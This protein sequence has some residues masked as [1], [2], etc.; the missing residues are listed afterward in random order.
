[1]TY[2]QLQTN[3]IN[4]W[5]FDSVEATES[6]QTRIFST[7]NP[8][9]FFTT[10]D[11][12]YFNL[13]FPTPT[14][15]NLFDQVVLEVSSPLTGLFS[16]VIDLDFNLLDDYIDTHSSF[17][18]TAFSYSTTKRLE[19]RDSVN[20]PINFALSD[21]TDIDKRKGGFSK[22][23]LIDGTKENS[24]TLNFYFDVNLS[25]GQFDRKKRVPCEIIQDGLSIFQGFLRLLKINRESQINTLDQ[26]IIYEVIVADDTA[27]FFQLLEGNIRDGYTKS[28]TTYDG[29]SDL[30]SG[31]DL[32]FM[33][34][35]WDY[36][37]VLISQSN[38]VEE[39]YKYIFPRA[40]FDGNDPTQLF[41]D[42]G[43][44]LTLT[45]RLAWSMQQMLPAIYAKIYWDAIFNS[46]GFTYEWESMNS[47][48]IMFD[49]LLIPHNIEDYPVD[50]ESSV[51]NIGQYW[52]KPDGGWLNTNTSNGSYADISPTL[53][54]GSVINLNSFKIDMLKRDFIKSILTMFNLYVELDREKPNN[55]IVKTRDEFYDS[56]VKKDWTTKTDF[57]KPNTIVFTPE[58][59]Q[60]R[61]IF[62]YSDG[63]RFQVKQYKENTGETSGTGIV[64]FDDEFIKGEKV[65][66]IKFQPFRNQ[67]FL[68][69]ND[70]GSEYFPYMSSR[71]VLNSRDINIVYDVGFTLF[72]PSPSNDIYLFGFNYLGKTNDNEYDITILNTNGQVR[73]SL[74]LN[75]TIVS[76]FYNY[77][78]PTDPLFS[79][80]YPQFDL[81]FGINRYY[82]ITP[83][84]D[85]RTYP[86]YNNL[87]TVHYTRTL[88]Q[89][90]DGK[91]LTAYINL[92]PYDIY[93]LKM[94][95]KI[96][97]KDA[98]WNIYKVVDYNANSNAPTK[99]ELLLA[100][101]FLKLTPFTSELGLPVFP[102]I[103]TGEQIQAEINTWN[104]ERTPIT[105]DV[106][107]TTLF[108]DNFEPYTGLNVG[109]N[110][111]VGAIVHPLNQS[112][113]FIPHNK[114]HILRVKPADTDSGTLFCK[115]IGN[116]T[117]YPDGGNGKFAGGVLAQ[118]GLI[119]L[120]PYN[121]DKIVSFD[122]ISETFSAV[123]TVPASG[124]KWWGGT[125][126]RNGKL[127]FAPAKSKD[128]LEF[129]P[130]TGTV[131]LIEIYLADSA[132]ERHKGCIYAQNDKIYFAPTNINQITW[133]DPIT[134]E[135]GSIDLNSINPSSVGKWIGASISK[136]FPLEEPVIVFG[137]DT[138]VSS[139]EG[140]LVLKIHMDG[141]P[142]TIS[143]V[144]LANANDP[145]TF[146]YPAYPANEISCGIALTPYMYN[147]APPFD[148]N[149]VI[150]YQF[151]NN[152]T[153]PYPST[154][155]LG[156]L[157]DNNYAGVIL[158]TNSFNYTVPFQSNQIVSIGTTDTLFWD[159]N[160]VYSPHLN[161]F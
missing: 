15:P 141:T 136:S 110:K 98:W 118:N 97:L 61:Q 146:G 111:F 82:D 150:G 67:K 81:N 2:I 69:R 75:Y 100:D 114:N 95:D 53:Q 44:G 79:L 42:T 156:L 9:Q 29:I 99:V 10:G 45:K 131:N 25:S 62:K 80:L 73:N 159:S 104:D 92:T 5:S 23:I 142:E 132:T 68:V 43:T 31:I 125:L 148:Y 18:G 130:N 6:G 36:D 8:E 138:L 105:E 153:F 47:D 63:D 158:H 121:S 50:N 35:T 40:W 22:T 107:I 66:E 151:S 122:P 145:T 124:Q 120:I 26:K 58:L 143:N 91:L 72:A 119:Y 134:Q 108:N 106:Q 96:W 127:Y 115:E 14:I 17:R 41:L 64:E 152:L 84:V 65:I 135:I 55:L 56:G 54:L 20:V 7:V 112:V 109:E 154:T 33:N 38:T 123:A 48:Y 39:G 90:Q 94:N 59:T 103:P 87:L 46:I 147:V 71:V 113:Y 30:D 21:I 160:I 49:K 126:H 116:L 13:E 28:K 76:N 11:A 70:A 16:I 101:N 140:N 1:M 12:V 128:L 157:L 85:L 137:V 78:N 89:I 24:K 149:R 155:T 34:H 77:E 60:K 139:T 37:S 57:T 88:Q 74:G 93:T 52:F 86:P 133:Y 27:T 129:D 83:L 19:L 161:K 144:S 117:G 32:S 51:N 3:T 4:K 102:E